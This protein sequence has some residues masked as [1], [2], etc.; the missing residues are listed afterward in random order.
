MLFHA[1]FLIPLDTFTVV[2]SSSDGRQSNASVGVLIVAGQP[3]VVSIQQILYQC[4]RYINF[5]GFLIVYV[6]I[7]FISLFSY[8]IL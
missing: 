3:P 4:Y 1:T 5:T 7:L 8:F 6:F 2:V